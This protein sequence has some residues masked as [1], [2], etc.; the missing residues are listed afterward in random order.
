MRLA[1]LSSANFRAS[2]PEAMK[3]A[4]E[5]QIPHPLNNVKYADGISRCR[6]AKRHVQ[7]QAC[8]QQVRKS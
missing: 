6:H 3:L 2:N 1:D 8:N 5:V 4:A 7:F